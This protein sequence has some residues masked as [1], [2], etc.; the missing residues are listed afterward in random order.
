MTKAV[1]ES[2]KGEDKR[3]TYYWQ[4]AREQ[5]ERYPTFHWPSIELMLNLVFTNDI[6]TVCVNSNLSKHNLSLSAFN[7]LMILHRS[8][9]KSLPLHEL[10]E[11][12]LVSK[13]NITGIIDSLEKRGLVSRVGVEGDRRI[14]L[15]CIT[16]AG[17]QLLESF[18]PHHFEEVK[19]SCSVLNE[20]EKATL[21]KLLTKLRRGL[22]ARNKEL[23]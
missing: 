17:E 1:L 16:A 18:L 19:Q 14:R 20:K 7:T 11:L 9:N 4:R 12:L 23:S 8:E 10:G 6:A 5:G 15:A 13:A 22:Q 2:I 3:D 21:S